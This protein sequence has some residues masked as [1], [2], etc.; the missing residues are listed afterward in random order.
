MEESNFLPGEGISAFQKYG[1][2][3]SSFYGLEAGIG[4]SIIFSPELKVRVEFQ[5]NDNNTELDLGYETE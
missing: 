1:K 5:K 4:F 3:G 2:P